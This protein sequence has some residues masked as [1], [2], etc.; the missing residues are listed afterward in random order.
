MADAWSCQRCGTEN[1]A[2]RHWCQEC[3]AT[4]EASTP[5]PPPPPVLAPAP[6]PVRATSGARPT[7]SPALLIGVV[8][9]VIAVGVGAF[10]VTRS[11][12]SSTKTATSDAAPGR[13]PAAQRTLD[14]QQV[15]DQLNFRTRDFPDQWTSDYGTKSASSEAGGAVNRAAACGGATDTSRSTDVVVESPVF[16]SG[17]FTA[18][19]SVQI[20]KSA[21][22]VASDFARL[23]SSDFLT[24]IHD[25]VVDELGGRDVCECL[26]LEV[27]A[28]EFP[29]PPN[30]P[31]LTYAF[32]LLITVHGRFVR[33]LDGILMGDGRTELSLLFSGTTGPF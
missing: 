22:A 4:Q 6:A 30:A 7:A 9:A 13:S 31:E 8:L 1:E 11:S 2:W 12:S 14:D 16:T 3:R 18:H 15:A 32:G 24:C 10:L 19:S 21:A 23:E 25:V 28:V 26:D 29:A 5:L 17:I 33:E 20:T 27:T